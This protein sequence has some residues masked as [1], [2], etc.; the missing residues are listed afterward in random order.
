[1]TFRD[2]PGRNV[3]RPIY[4]LALAN[5]RPN[6]I[7]V[8]VGVALGRGIAEMARILIDAKR[9]DVKLFAVDPFG[10]YA[11][12]GEQAAMAEA[13]GGDWAL[14][15]H[16]MQANAPE[17]LRRIHI[18]R[19][20]STA[21]ALAIR[22]PLDLVILD[23]DHTYHAVREDIDAWYPLVRSGGIIGGDDHHPVQFPG[24]EQACRETFG[25]P[26]T[27]YVVDDN[28]PHR[29]PVWHMVKP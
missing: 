5:T 6:G 29:W 12:N 7:W 2:I 13:A 16:H 14:F 1:V 20:D 22:E 17:E 9:H 15:L 21:A 4:E 25:A 19:A 23:A 26:G 10:G 8:E 18:L 28:N 3:M 24:V 11:R 27:G